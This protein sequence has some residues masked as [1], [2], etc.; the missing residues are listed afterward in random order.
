MQ[1][2][3]FKLITNTNWTKAR[4]EK[5]NPHK[6]MPTWKTYEDRRIKWTDLILPKFYKKP[7]ITSSAF[8][9]SSRAGIDAKLLALYQL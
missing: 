5:K 2:L 4:T 6:Q 7:H 3:G 1:A 9:L 8:L